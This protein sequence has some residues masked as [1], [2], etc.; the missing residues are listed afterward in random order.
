MRILSID[1]SVNNVGWALLNTDGKTPKERWR[2]GLIK[3]EGRNFAMKCVC[4]L[5]E[6]MAL[7]EG[8]EGLDLLLTEWPTF[9]DSS[10]GHMAA[11]QNYTVDL[12]GIC[13]YIAGGLGMDHRRWHLATATEWKGSV[14]KIVTARKFYRHFGKTFHHSIS[15]HEMDA[16]MLLHWFIRLKASSLAIDL[17][18]WPELA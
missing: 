4:L 12:A 2:T 8:E 6:L 18:T 15:E 13:G 17:S 9:F 16:A 5:Q 10:K 3:P 7:S 14:S 11:R 1:P